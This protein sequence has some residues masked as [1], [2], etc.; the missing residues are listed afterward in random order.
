VC[1]KTEA[2]FTIETYAA[3]RGPV[4]VAVFNPNRQHERVGDH[5]ISVRQHER[6]GDH[7][8][9]VRQHER[10]GDHVISVRQHEREGDHTCD[11]GSPA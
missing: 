1:V 7:V 8:I 5:V 9:S 10:V 3:G 6:V 11:I 2:R 4:G